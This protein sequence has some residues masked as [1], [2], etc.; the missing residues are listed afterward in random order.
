VATLQ[1]EIAY[2]TKSIKMRLTMITLAKVQMPSTDITQCQ[3][4]EKKVGKKREFAHAKFSPNNKKVTQA[5][6]DT[7]KMVTFFQKSKLS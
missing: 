5:F 2:K 3:H 4:V 6:D 7:E 1:D